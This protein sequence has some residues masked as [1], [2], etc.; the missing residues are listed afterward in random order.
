MEELIKQMI[1]L[2]APV[3]IHAFEAHQKLHGTPPT[4][5]QLR[6]I[7]DTHADAILAKGEAWELSHPKVT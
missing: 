5:E 4:V 1:A 7:L 6:A 3:V 2:L